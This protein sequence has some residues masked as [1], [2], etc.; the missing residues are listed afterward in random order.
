MKQA[1]QII[2]KFKKRII[3]IYYSLSIKRRISLSF[4]LIFLSSLFIMIMII[5][6]L[7]SDSVVNKTVENTIQN[8]DLVS[9]KLD[10]LCDNI[11]NF[12]KIAVFNR[13]IQNILSDT[14][15]RTITFDENI[16]VQTILD[17]IIIAKTGIDAMIIYQPD[18]N[19]I[20]SGHI[21]NLNYPIASR[22]NLISALNT[23][24]TTMKWIDTYRSFY[25]KDHQ[26]RNVIS[27]IKIFNSSNSGETLG[28]IETTVDERNILAMYSKI[29]IGNTGQI[30]ITNKDGMIISGSDEVRLSAHSL[31]GKPD[32][33]IKNM[34]YFQWS[35]TNEGGKIFKAS[36]ENVLVINKHYLRNNWYIIGTV[37]VKEIIVES[38]KLTRKIF[39]IGFF[40]IIIAFLLSELMSYTITKPIMKLK[41]TIE[42]V[43][44]GDF[45]V[46]AEVQFNDE[47]GALAGAFNKMVNKT[48]N[49]MDSIVF[50]QKRKREY[51][52]AMLQAQI[53]PHFLYNTLENICVLQ[54]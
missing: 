32:G 4:M 41:E 39:I 11:E 1:Q 52:L 23:S 20:D 31:A 16:A 2:T 40:F 26:Y 46:I 49:L 34:P 8:L 21:S 24:F 43:G 35:L 12:S 10:L 45:G 53:N 29:Q 17:N 5:S 3:Y 13:D 9:E 47:I 18:K 25:E 30:F 19:I 7:S 15:G 44:Q 38:T 51:E 33:S 22:K 54:N 14:N 50:E 27:F 37:P 28:I 36:N 48:S 6:R 42:F